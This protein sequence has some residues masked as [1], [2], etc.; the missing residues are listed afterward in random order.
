MLEKGH[1][2]AIYSGTKNNEATKMNNYQQIMIIKETK[3]KVNVINLVVLY[4]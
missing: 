1:K 2:S 3:S 4:H